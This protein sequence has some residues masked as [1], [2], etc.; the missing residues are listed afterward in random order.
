[1]SAIR[2]LKRR[3]DLLADATEFARTPGVKAAAGWRE[4]GASGKYDHGLR[5]LAEFFVIRVAARRVRLS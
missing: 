3:L 1:M 2:A 5:D 4:P